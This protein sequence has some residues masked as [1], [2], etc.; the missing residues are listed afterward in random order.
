VKTVFREDELAHLERGGL[1]RELLAAHAAFRSLSSAIEAKG[2]Y[3]FHTS[4]KTKFTLQK[5]DEIGQGGQ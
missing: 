4:D 5:R 2:F 3:I 1:V